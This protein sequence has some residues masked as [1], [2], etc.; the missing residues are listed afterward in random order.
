VRDALVVARVVF[1]RRFVL[2]RFVRH[3]FANDVHDDDDDDDDDDD[4]RETS[5]FNARWRRSG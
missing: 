4:V 5:H 2:F 3:R 1:L